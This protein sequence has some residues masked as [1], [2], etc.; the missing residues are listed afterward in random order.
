MGHDDVVIWLNGGPGCSSLDGLFEENGPVTLRGGKNVTVEKN[1]YSWTNLSYMVYVDNPVGAGLST[2]NPDIRGE[3]DLAREF[4]GFLK[5]FFVTFKELRG[6]RLW[7]T[8]ESYA[9]MY[10]PYIAHEIYR[11]PYNASGIN[12]QGIAINDPLFTTMFLGEQAPAFEYFEQ[13]HKVMGLNSSSV[14]RVRGLAKKLGVETYVRDNLHYP[15]KGPIHVPSSWNASESVWD[16]INSIA[17][18]TNSCFSVYDIK[19]NCGSKQDPLGMPLN[20]QK[21]LKRNFIN[22]TPG[23]KRAIHVD[24]SKAW[25]ECTDDNVFQGA[26]RHDDSSPPPDRSVLPGVIEKSRRTVIQHG[27]YDY[28][29]IANGTAL[30]IQNMTWHGQMGFQHKPDV[31]FKVDGKVRGMMR[32]ERGL[33]FFLVDGSGHMVPQFKPKT[34]YKLQ[35]YL[36]GQVTRDDLD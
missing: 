6:K 36:L 19:P 27:T 25:T 14:E 23:L 8:G 24:E 10:I 30:A 7:L 26:A 18:K 1:K 5:Q 15:P 29:L 35:Q 31:P 34:A 32:E 22:D 2:G 33:S 17:T 12:L 9:G 3:R 13:Y 11:H 16:S 21:A 28:V 20:S 4:Y